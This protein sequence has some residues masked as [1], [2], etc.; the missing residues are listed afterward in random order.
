MDGC[1]LL[2]KINVCSRMRLL[3]SL[4]FEPRAV[5]SRVESVSAYLLA[6]P[7]TVGS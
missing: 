2:L 6:R 5:K 7:F 1:E 4:G 3:I